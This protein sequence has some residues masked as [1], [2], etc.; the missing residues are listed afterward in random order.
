MVG[1]DAV[2]R[3][4]PRYS[5]TKI[6]IEDEEKKVAQTQRQTKKFHYT[7]IT[8][9]SENLEELLIAEVRSHHQLPEETIALMKTKIQEVR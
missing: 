5:F 9:T 4:F 2:R 1:L 8:I 6:N 3:R 7:P